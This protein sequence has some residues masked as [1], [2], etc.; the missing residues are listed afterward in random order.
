MISNDNDARIVMMPNDNDND[1]DN[2]AK[3]VMM[4]NDNDND[5]E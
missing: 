4:P 2:D 3:I 1:D 5:D